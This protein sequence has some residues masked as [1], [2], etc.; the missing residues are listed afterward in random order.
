M[1]KQ[2]I[3]RE[4]I[5]WNLNDFH[6]P[7]NTPPTPPLYATNKKWSLP[8]WKEKVIDVFVIFFTLNSHLTPIWTKTKQLNNLCCIES[9]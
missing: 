7:S 9:Q 2:L 3:F 8:K 1:N 5:S 4:K 6:Q